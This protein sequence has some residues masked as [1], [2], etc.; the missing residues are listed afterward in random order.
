MK[1]VYIVSGTD[2][3]I[4]KTVACAMLVQALQAD[5]FKPIQAGLDQQTDTQTIKRLC[6]L[7]DSRIVPELHRLNTPASPHHAAD[8][9]DIE[10]DADA[11]K[12]PQRSNTLIVEGAGGLMV[13]VNHTAL[14]IDVFKRWGHPVIVCARTAL[15]TINHSLLSINALNERGIAVHGIIF[16]GESMP[17]SELAICNFSGV[18]RLGRIPRL[19]SLDA[20]S[21]QKTF[22]RE[23]CRQDFI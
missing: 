22:D 17:S 13:P 11:L 21:L 15:G 1:P 12:L 5:Y 16:I 3:E 4:G 23:F 10:I 7:D 2:T 20:A 19:E 9:D 18:R 14:F 8:I 6:N